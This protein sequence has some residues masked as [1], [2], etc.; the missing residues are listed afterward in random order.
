MHGSLCWRAARFHGLIRILVCICKP[1]LS[2]FCPGVT[3]RRY[4]PNPSAAHHTVFYPVQQLSAV[5]FREGISFT[6]SKHSSSLSTPSSLS[7]GAIYQPPDAND[8]AALLNKSFHPRENEINSRE[9]TPFIMEIP[10]GVDHWKSVTRA[11]RCKLE[12][13]LGKPATGDIRQSISYPHYWKIE[14]KHYAEYW[15]LVTGKLSDQFD[16]LRSITTDDIRYLISDIHY[17][18]TEAMHYERYASGTHW[19]YV[20]V[21]KRQPCMR[22]S[23]RPSGIRKRKKAPRSTSKV[24]SE[25]AP[26]SSRLRSSQRNRK[27][28]FKPKST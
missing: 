27:E 3:F 21:Q 4:R 2:Y 5:S 22:S 12:K 13:L 20:A 28:G 17:W 24:T 25:D 1:T 16:S 7:A 8:L 26:V 6:M 19:E 23:Q 18:E 11:A 10:P 15:D 9:S 14:A